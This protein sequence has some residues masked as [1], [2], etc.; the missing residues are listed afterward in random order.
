[1]YF[2]VDGNINTITLN[3]SNTAQCIMGRAWVRLLTLFPLGDEAVILNYP[4][5]NSYQW[6]ISPVKLPTGECHKTDDDGLDRNDS[7][8]RFG[9]IGQ[10][11]ITWTNADL[12]LCR[13]MASLS[14]NGLTHKHTLYLIITGSYGALLRGSLEKDDHYMSKLHWF[15]NLMEPEQML[16]QSFQ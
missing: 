14:H 10:Q 1:M 5:W 11:S 6:Q 15:N 7:D 3:I 13:H 8:N 4:F 16:S 2:I 12:D 9:A